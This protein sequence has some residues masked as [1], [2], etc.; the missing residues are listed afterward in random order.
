M[1]HPYNLSHQAF[2]WLARLLA[3]AG[4]PELSLVA[5]PCGSLGPTYCNTRS[6]IASHMRLF[7]SE[8]AS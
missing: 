6:Q 7:V 8:G 5:E 3:H 2:S 1:P 4:G